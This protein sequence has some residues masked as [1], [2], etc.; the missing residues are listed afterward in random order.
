MRRI[1]LAT[2]VWMVLGLGPLVLS[3]QYVTRQLTDNQPVIILLALIGTIIVCAIWSGFVQKALFHL[4]VMG[5]PI[6]TPQRLRCAFGH[7]QVV[8]VIDEVDM[9]SV[10]LISG[11][12]W[13]MERPGLGNV[14]ARV[15]G[16]VRR[17]HQACL[18]GDWTETP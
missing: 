9:T 18:R 4:I 16:T 1:V 2:M 14:R 17:S 8:R 5:R 6:P 7:H 3:V 10:D 12:Q 11:E 15:T 13:V